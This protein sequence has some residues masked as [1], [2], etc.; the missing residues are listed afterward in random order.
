[1]FPVVRYYNYLQSFRSIRQS[2]P[3]VE[4]HAAHTIPLSDLIVDI[5]NGLN[6]IDDRTTRSFGTN[7]DGIPA[8]ILGTHNVVIPKEYMD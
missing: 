3:A 1:M 4:M 6:S 8:K 2:D 7:F 5:E